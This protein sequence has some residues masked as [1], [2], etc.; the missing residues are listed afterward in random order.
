MPSIVAPLPSCCHHAGVDSQ[1]GCSL[2]A[3]TRAMMGPVDFL[4]PKPRC[5]D[6]RR[7]GENVCSLSGLPSTTE[8]RVAD[9]KQAM[10]V[11]LGNTACCMVIQQILDTVVGHR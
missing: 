8:D 10:L 11:C 2:V 9:V 6:D 7:A 4:P 1:Q 3:L 5:C